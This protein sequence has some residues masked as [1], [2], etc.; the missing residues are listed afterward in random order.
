MLEK[1]SASI[2]NFPIREFAP[3]VALR[4]QLE[5]TE[6]E[7]K[8]YELD[9]I[10]EAAADDGPLAPAL[11]EAGRQRVVTFDLGIV[12]ACNFE[13]GEPPQRSSSDV[14]IDG[15]AGPQ[16]APECLCSESARAK[17]GRAGNHDA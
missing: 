13:R 16:K 9:L 14:A 6:V 10:R 11:D 12:T 7:F 4:R 3:S 17:S 8:Q 2:R 1:S 5:M 15:G